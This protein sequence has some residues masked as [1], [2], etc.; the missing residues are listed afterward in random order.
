MKPFR[1][2]R[3]IIKLTNLDKILYIL[4]LLVITSSLVV[5]HF[6]NE[7]DTFFDGFWWSMT[8]ITTV[9]YG[10]IVITTKIGRITGII[11]MVYGII[12][13]TLITSTIVTF[14]IELNR[15]KRQHDLKEINEKLSNLT[16]LSK[17]ELENLQT[18]IKQFLDK[19]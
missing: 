12:L 9:G 6:E 11:L 13:F 8:T 18:K 3:K 7:V 4:A 15:I 19:E 1:V 5:M 2:F 14:S 16:S 10:D 17:Q